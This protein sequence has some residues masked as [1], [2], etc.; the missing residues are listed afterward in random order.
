MG[1]LSGSLPDKDPDDF[2]EPAVLD[3]N[4]LLRRHPAQHTRLLGVTRCHAYKL[5]G[6]TPTFPAET[7][8]PAQDRR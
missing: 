6:S 2:G 4:F 3:G 8:A 7:P 1:V 5:V